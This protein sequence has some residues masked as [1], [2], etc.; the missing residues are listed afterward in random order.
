MS[1]GTRPANPDARWD[2]EFD[3]VV[4]GSGA[5]G[6]TS[7]ICAHDLGQST[8][9]IEKSDQY[10][11]TT[12]IS[13]GGVWVPCNHLLEA[14]GGK[15]SVDEA[16]TYLRQATRGMVAEERIL[17]YLEQAPRMLR[18]IEDKTH[19]KYRT[20]SH[21]SDYYPQLKGSKPGYRTLDP[22]PC[23]AGQLGDDFKAMRPPQPGTL[24][25]G[26]VA[27]TA[28]EAHTLLTKESGW[29]ALFMKRMASYWLDIPWRFRN[30]RDRRMT[31]G[32]ALIGSL[33]RSMIDRNI[34]LWLNTPLESLV[35]DS[36]GIVG[37]VANQNGKTIRIGARRGVILAAGGFE[38]NQSMREQYLPKPTRAEWTVTPEANTGDAIR[39]GQ[40]VGA[41]VDLMDHAW[42]APTVFIHGR[43]KRRAL[44]VERAL[45]G[46]VMVNRNGR[47]F[48]D[49]AAPYSDIVYA[50][51][52][53][54]E[55][56]GANL[57]AWLIFDAEFRRKY[58]CGPLL[59][60]MARP[61]K[62][63]PSSWVGSVFYRS[64]SLD[65]LA[66]EI[67]VDNEG[68]LATI[69]KMNEYARTGDDKEFGKGSNTFDRYY[70][71][72]N[73]KPNPCLAP[74]AKPPFYAMRID[75]GDIGTKGGLLT[76][77]YARVLREDGQPIPGLYATGNTS[78]AVMGPSYPGA[79]STLGPA[80]TFGYIAAHHLAGV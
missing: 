26:R 61:D 38:H 67:E 60:G 54:N 51:Y 39:A 43:E 3:V 65:D 55:K 44:F 6:M 35:T 5:G 70:G 76:D 28:G 42:W 2:H 11:G 69:D 27:M 79:G 14:A 46:C 29:I 31:L 33:R 58:P 80:M 17:A 56:S 10:G 68:L 74:I 72:L 40:S 45:P 78:A 63:L 19:L 71:D 57:P 21:Y 73:V 7:A 20:M 66:K 4:V 8:V 16:L 23:D 77:E 50:M 22:L 9:L 52:A 53:D 18:Y 64:D 75:A 34:P 37:V 24:I 25:A 12:A 62:S 41:K 30:K 36:R 48:V 59:P 13:G 47:R 15:D 1:G 32:S 49:E